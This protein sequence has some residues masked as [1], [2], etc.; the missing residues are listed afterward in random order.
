MSSRW[1]DLA[2]TS[3]RIKPH[4]FCAI[5]G[6]TQAA[7]KVHHSV[8]REPQRLKPR[9]FRGLYGMP[10]GMPFQRQSRKQTSSQPLQAALQRQIRKQTF[11]R[12]LKACP[13]KPV[14]I[15]IFP[16]L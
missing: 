8:K 9:S 16:H 15:G 1:D 10:E 2:R 3:Q 5:Y 11:Q 6:T 4:S 14:A 7:E 13:F 12:P